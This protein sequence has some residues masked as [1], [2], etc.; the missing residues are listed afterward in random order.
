[1]TKLYRKK[2][3]EL[4]YNLTK[5]RYAEFKYISQGYLHLTISIR[6]KKNIISD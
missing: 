4:H 3:P 2:V 6:V 1:M 5:D